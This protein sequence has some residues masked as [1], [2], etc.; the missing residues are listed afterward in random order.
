MGSIGK[1][2]LLVFTEVGE[3]FLVPVGDH[4]SKGVATQHVGV[5]TGAA[6]DKGA[7]E[8]N[9][10]LVGDIPQGLPL[11]GPGRHNIEVL[12]EREGGIHRELLLAQEGELLPTGLTRHLIQGRALRLNYPL[13]ELTSELEAKRDH[14]ETVREEVK[15]VEDHLVVATE[16]LGETET[17]QKEVSALIDTTRRAHEDLVQRAREAVLA[18][19]PLVT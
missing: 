10:V 15:R 13:G 1:V 2:D 18:Q 17:R 4:H 3:F 14:L 8:R 9:V 16:Q 19:R 12:T 5:A 6:R 11:G 7:L